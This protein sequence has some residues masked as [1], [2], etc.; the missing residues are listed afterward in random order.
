MVIW[1]LSVMDQMELPEFHQMM[2]LVPGWKSGL[3]Y[4][5]RVHDQEFNSLRRK[6]QPK[7][8]RQRTRQRQEKFLYVCETLTGRG[9]DAGNNVTPALIHCAKLLKT[10]TE[11]SRKVT[12]A[13]AT[14]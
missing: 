10:H 1:P 11:S 13:E 4:I 6:L 8:L 14:F 3:G 9:K 12:P 2:R 5:V 7:A